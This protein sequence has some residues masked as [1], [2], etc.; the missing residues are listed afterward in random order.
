MRGEPETVIL[1]A[2][3]E[4][5]LSSQESVVGSGTHGLHLMP[6]G[7]NVVT[8]CGREKGVGQNGQEGRI[9]RDGE[10]GERGGGERSWW[11]NRFIW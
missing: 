7:M 6:M 1:V 4:R 8:G 9:C 10:I 5:C 3:G 11:R 2:P